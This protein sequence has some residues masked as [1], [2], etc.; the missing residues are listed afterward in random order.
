MPKK[1]WT[2]GPPGLQK[3]IGEWLALKERNALGHPSDSETY[4]RC[5]SIA[6]SAGY[7]MPPPAT[8][9]LEKVNALRA[10]GEWSLLAELRCVHGAE[11]QSE[12]RALNRYQG[13]RRWAAEPSAEERSEQAR[14]DQAAREF[15]VAKE[16]RIAELVADMDAE[17]AAKRRL[18]AIKQIE[19]EQRT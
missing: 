16:R 7:D 6:Y 2:E 12:Q 3:R 11:E 17:A 8:P 1:I 15:E 9:I 14:A 4:I 18:A 10:A 13:L 5:S 19:K